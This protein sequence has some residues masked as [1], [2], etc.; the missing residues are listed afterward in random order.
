ML[1]IKNIGRLYSG[2]FSPNW[3]QEFFRRYTFLALVALSVVAGIM[4][5]ATVAYQASMTE[6]AQQVAALASYRPNLVTRVLADDGKT[7]VGEFSLERRIPVTYD[8]IPDQLRQAI[9]AIEDDRFFQHIGVDPIRIVMAG[10]KNVTSGRKAEGASTLTQQLA[11]AL[12]LSPEKT[13]ARKVK[14][15]LLSLQI[16][17]Y[18]TK[19]QIMEMYCNQ[20]FLGGGAYGFEAGSQYYFSK[21]LK[22]LSLEECAL[23]AGLPKA[24]S[25]YSP[26]RDEKAARDRRNIVLFRMREEG[27]IAEDEYSRAKQTAI[28]LNLNPQTT[29]NDSIFGYFVED[30][31]QEAEGTF[32]TRQTLTEGMNI[33]TTIDAYAQREAVRAVRHGLHAYQDRHGKK[34]RGNLT[35]VLSHKPGYDLGNYVHPDWLGDFVAGE[36]IYGLV[37][38]TSQA[39][40]DI[41]FGDYRATLTDAGTKWAGG[42]PARLLKR[43]DLAV[44]KVIKADNDKKVL[45]VSLDEL[46]LV[47]GALVCIESRTGD[48]KA[49]VGGYDFLTRKFNNATQAERQTG[50]AFKPFIYTAAIEN[51]FSPDTVVN[52]GPFTDPSTGWSPHNYDGSLGGGMLPLRTALQQSL[53]VVA[54]RL[55]SMVGVD[56]GAEVVKRFGLSNPMKRVL[57]SALGATEEPLIDMVS[58]YSTFSN[59]GVRVKPHLIRQVTDADGNTF[60]G[61]QWDP[62]SYKVITPYVAAQM[63]DM[64]RGVVTGGTGGPI[65]GNKELAKRMICGKT[66]TVND[67]T[68]A[69]FIGYTPTY[70]AGVWIGY[71]G[72]KRTLGNREAGGVA[73][74]PMWMQFMEKFLKDKPNDKFPK[75]PPPDKEVLARRGEAERAIRKAAAEEAE[76]NAQ[77]PDATADQAKSAAK[78]AEEPKPRGER[79][80]PRMIEPDGGLPPRRNERPKVLDRP[81]PI[82]DRK[83]EGDKPKK[84][85]KNG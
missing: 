35:N 39:G 20:I 45:D 59:L 22:D 68:D 9:W 11:R 79:P 19:E 53:N 43:G 24:P 77:A 26:T 10:I 28:N 17:R 69:W 5:G 64:M 66:G 83:H 51:G 84:R 63:Q 76:A 47:D 18:Y 60:E 29:N 42:T 48:V 56:K 41:R 62:E 6:E 80:I 36:Y 13:Y 27:Y 30:V 54:V 21:S 72:Q 61:G 58:A 32:G 16:E 14:E 70:T 38:G 71:P 3:F 46:P 23:L 49:M 7:V 74:L 15:I 4:F 12:F 75:A 34:W 85:G 55:L 73:A 37:M 52:A 25:L 65:M 67:F 2:G 82:E 33:Y 50:S 44:F 40:A 8:E 57:P 1:N 78:D 31:R 81:P